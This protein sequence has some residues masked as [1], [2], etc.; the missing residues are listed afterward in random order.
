MTIW[1]KARGLLKVLWHDFEISRY[2]AIHSALGIVN[3]VIMLVLLQ[4]WGWNHHTATFVGHAF[5][6]VCGFYADRYFSFRSFETKTVIGGPKY[7]IIE[8]LSYI[9][10][11]GSMYVFSDILERD[12]LIVRFTISMMLA[13]VISFGA[14]KYWTFK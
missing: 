11:V 10:I 5:H 1:Q 2:A 4:Y 14:N 13:S 6:V 12:P 7:V 3:V 9:S 8:S